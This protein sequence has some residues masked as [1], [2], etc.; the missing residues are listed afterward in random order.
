MY[1]TYNKLINI[2]QEQIPDYTQKQIKEVLSA[3][4]QTITDKV[5]EGDRVW[6]MEL[7]TFFPVEWQ[8]GKAFG[9]EV[10][11]RNIVMYRASKSFKEK[12]KK[13]SQS[14]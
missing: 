6:Y 3:T 5:A 8:H 1:V 9:H 13:A 14:K 11:P 2:I 4:A 10:T 7:G 12:V